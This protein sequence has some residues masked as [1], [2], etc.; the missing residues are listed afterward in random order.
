MWVHRFFALVLVAAFAAAC[1][2]KS[3][4]M[5]GGEAGAGAE[6][7]EGSVECDGTCR[8][9]ANDE[10]NCGA[11]GR[12][13]ADDERCSGGRCVSTATCPPG[14]TLCNGACVDLSSADAH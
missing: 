7:N 11:C 12:R 10:R 6:C 8:D 5:T 14:M 2:G 3:V 9:I 4:E 13:C 1:G